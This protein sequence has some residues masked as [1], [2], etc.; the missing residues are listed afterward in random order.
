[1]ILTHINHR[2]HL[3]VEV[4]LPDVLLPVHL[5]PLLPKVVRLVQQTADRYIDLFLTNGKIKLILLASGVSP[6]RKGTLGCLLH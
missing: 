2:N 5:D 4:P 1:M 3:T 6:G